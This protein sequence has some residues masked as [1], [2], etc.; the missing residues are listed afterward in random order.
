[1]RG[2]GYS[3]G[4]RVLVWSISNQ[5]KV[6]AAKTCQLGIVSGPECYLL[7]WDEA[8]SRERAKSICDWPSWSSYSSHGD[9]SLAVSESF[10]LCSRN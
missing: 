7:L 2:F 6:S 9:C 8:S 3:Q 1:M 4:S 5:V 10:S